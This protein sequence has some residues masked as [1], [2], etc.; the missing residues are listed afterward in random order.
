MPAP[1]MVK[2]LKEHPECSITPAGIVLDG[3]GWPIRAGGLVHA[4]PYAP[5]EAKLAEKANKAKW[6]GLF[7][8]P[9]TE[10]EAQFCASAKA[11]G[12]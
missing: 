11:A 9:M 10:T 2:F 8:L 1:S 7:A 5:H 4:V 6:A 12:F 3:T